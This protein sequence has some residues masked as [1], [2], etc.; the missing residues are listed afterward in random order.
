MHGEDVVGKVRGVEGEVVAEVALE[1][2]PMVV[3]HV[4]DAHAAYGVCS[5]GRFPAQFL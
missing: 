4:V 3:Q 5:S 1:V 2:A